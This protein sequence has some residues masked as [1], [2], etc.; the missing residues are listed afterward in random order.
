MVDVALIRSTVPDGFR[1]STSSVATSGSKNAAD[2]TDC[3]IRRDH[4]ANLGF[5]FTS[6]LA[7]SETLNVYGKKVPQADSEVSV[8]PPVDDAKYAVIGAPL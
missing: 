2:K 1:E 3:V 8:T 6:E 7:V 4:V 5:N